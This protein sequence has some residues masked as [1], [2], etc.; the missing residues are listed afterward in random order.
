[1][2]AARDSGRPVRWVVPLFLY[3]QLGAFAAWRALGEIFTRPT[4]WH[5]TEHGVSPSSART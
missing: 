5:K 1:M 2:V 4:Y 3:W